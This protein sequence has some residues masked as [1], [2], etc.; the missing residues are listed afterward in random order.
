L[1]ILDEADN[2]TA[3][4][5][6]ALRRLMEMYSTTTRF[7]LLANFPSKIIEPV[8]SRCVY[9]RF[10]PLP[11]DKVIE[12]LKYICQKEGVQCEEDAL[13]EIYN[14]SEGDM[15]KAINI[16]QAAAALGKVTKDAV[17]KAIGY[18][19]PSKIKE[20]LEYAL[21]GDFT[22][23][24]KLLRDVMIEYGLSGLDVLKMFQRELMGGS[25]EL[26]EELKVL[27]ADYAGEVQFRLAEGADDEVQLQAFLAR[28]ALLGP[29]FKGGAKR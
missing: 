25:F 19:H 16:L 4:A 17:Y 3:D 6:Q 13:E 7:I 29:K 11:K 26:P 8:Q 9:F 18:V 12:R 10:R 15:R 1:V 14:I 23:S 28:L 5:Q 22:K 2:M 27:L 24:A 20:I 21:N